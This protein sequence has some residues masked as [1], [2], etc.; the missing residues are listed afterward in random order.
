[1]TNALTLAA[2]LRELDD[3]HLAATIAAR[4]VSVS[5]VHDF[6]DL[7]DALLERESVQRA[8]SRLDRRTLAVIAAAAESGR[9]ATG[10]Q[11]ADRLSAWGA[12][13]EPQPDA[14][15]ER[16]RRP[17]ELMLAE[18]ANGVT[19]V[20]DVVREVLAGWPERGLPSPAELAASAPPAAAA[21]PGAERERT[22]RLA[23]E[24]AFTAVMAVTEL[25]SELS[26]EPALELQKGGL[27]LP[28]LKRL[29][30]ALSVS[31]SDV[32][33]LLSVAARAGLVAR[34]HRDWLATESGRHWSARPTAERWGVL[35]DAWYESLPHDIRQV[36]RGRSHAPWGEGLQ[37][38]IAWS[39]PAAGDVLRERVAEFT[40]DAEILGLTAESLPS[41][42][43]SVLLE[44]G[45]TEAS[46]LMAGM[47]PAEVDR[48]YLQHDLSIVAPGPVQPAVDARLRTVADVE[49]RALAFTYRVSESSVNRAI[50]AGDTA[51][52]L[53]TFLAG[54]SLTGVPQ[55]L[56]YLVAEAERRFGLVRVGAIADADAHGQDSKAR[57][58]VRSD[59]TD[60]LHTLQVDQSLSA[61]GLSAGSGGRLISRFGRDEVYWALTD[62]RYPVAAEDAAGDIVSLTRGRTATARRLEHRDRAAEL[63]ATLRS[64]EAE[65]GPDAAKAWLA[66][67]LD[68][69]VRARVTLLV[70]VVMPD[71]RAVDYC[72]EP[73]GV[74]GGRLR[75][76][77]RTVDVERT[78]PLSS[79]SGIRPA[80]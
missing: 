15:A 8:L 30:T 36:M 66:R 33:G 29:S 55:P 9:A 71:G 62:A 35:V 69:A 1:M 61:L 2:R 51:E 44:H 31:L 41:G 27:A 22:D 49:G 32:P 37:Q 24:R 80:G 57:S 3:V 38:L 4:G 60:V 19:S 16:L 28:S 7:A 58:Y 25:L 48:V 65:A 11:I 40:R 63:V 77:D 12:D 54:I 45:V 42:P 23:S 20:Y 76:R 46:D 53:L 18:T 13:T 21:A 10:A 64:A 73:T 78:F 74:G 14:I 6:F 47:F 56:Q 39:F 34:Q 75:G 50:A 68:V 67:Q 5:G 43:G 70:T 72:L 59:D 79:I 26:A 52:G 17:A